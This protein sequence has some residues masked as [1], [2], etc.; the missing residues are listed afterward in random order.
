MLEVLQG[1]GKDLVLEEEAIVAL[2]EKAEAYMVQVLGQANRLASHGNRVT[3]QPKDIHLVRHL[4]QK[5]PSHS[6][7][8]EKEL[9]TAATCLAI[10]ACR[11]TVRQEDRE[12]VKEIRGENLGG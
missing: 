2:H 10:H 1:L 9:E 8:Y 7:N 11:A 3:V 4:R 12:L 6:K 5:H